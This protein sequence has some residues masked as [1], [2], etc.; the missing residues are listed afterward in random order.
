MLHFKTLHS[1]QEDYG[2]NKKKKRQN[3][4]NIY[5]MSK[6]SPSF[7]FSD[8]RV[9]TCLI[10]RPVTFTTSRI[11]TSSITPCSCQDLSGSEEKGSCNGDSLKW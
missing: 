4:T 3:S 8:L 10:R 1:R 9:T 2:Q 5:L 6:L 7:P 11:Y